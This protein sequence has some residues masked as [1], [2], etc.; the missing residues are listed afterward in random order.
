MQGVNKDF[1]GGCER[2]VKDNQRALRYDYCK[3]WFHIVPEFEKREPGDRK[4]DNTQM[5]KKIFRELGVE[6]EIENV[7]RLERVVENKNRLTKVV[8]KK[9]LKKRE[10]F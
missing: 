5:V 6:A 4:E 3:F 10:K 9:T 1:C 8:L 7:I 2:E